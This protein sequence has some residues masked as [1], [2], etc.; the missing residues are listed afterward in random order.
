MSPNV[1]PPKP[2]GE[3]HERKHARL[4][5]MMRVRVREREMGGGGWGM[6]D[7]GGGGC[8]CAAWWRRQARWEEIQQPIVWGG[9]KLTREHQSGALHGSPDGQ[10]GPKVNVFEETMFFELP[11][12]Q[13]GTTGSNGKTK[14]RRMDTHQRSSAGWTGHFPYG[15]VSFRPLR[16]RRLKRMRC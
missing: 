13:Y 1:P 6:V 12:G 8:R 9:R 5:V 11:V 14:G 16:P 7:G 4:S 15:D 3:K 10:W 2:S